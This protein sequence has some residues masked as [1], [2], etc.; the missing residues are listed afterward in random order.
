MLKVRIIWSAIVNGASFTF[1]LVKHSTK[2]KAED[3]R[4][5]KMRGGII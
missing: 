2:N 3:Y 4:S 1:Q 5:Q